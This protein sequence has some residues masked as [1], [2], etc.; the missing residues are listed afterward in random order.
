MLQNA[1]RTIGVRLLVVE[2]TSTGDLEAA[3]RKLVDE[4][5]GAF[6]VAADPLFFLSHAE[7]AS[8]EARYAIPSIHYYR[9]AIFAGGLMSYAP[10]PFEISR[11]VG[12]HRA[13][14]KG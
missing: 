8:F 5:A 6:L 3:F 4:R 7:I 2:A 14:P 13:N 10:N 1:A 12:V 9:E 11:I